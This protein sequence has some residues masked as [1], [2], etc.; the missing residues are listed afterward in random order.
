MHGATVKKKMAYKFDNKFQL[1][2]LVLKSFVKE[3]K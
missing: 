1:N 3:Y 2:I